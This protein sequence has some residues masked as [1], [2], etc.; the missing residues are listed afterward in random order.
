MLSDDRGRTTLL[1]VGDFV[2]AYLGD[3][4]GTEVPGYAAAP[5]RFE[6]RE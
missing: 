4:P 5:V 2:E 1:T 3:A 6:A